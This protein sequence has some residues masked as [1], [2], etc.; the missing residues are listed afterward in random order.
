MSV[1]MDPVDWALIPIKVESKDDLVIID[2]GTWG[3]RY[4]ELDVRLAAVLAYKL[5]EVV[6]RK[7]VEGVGPSEH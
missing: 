5:D 4:I 6:S 2:L 3:Y 7:L 1:E